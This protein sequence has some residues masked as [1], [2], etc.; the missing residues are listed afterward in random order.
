MY[1]EF[2][3]AMPHFS[4]SG[5]ILGK[6]TLFNQSEELM[7]LRRPKLKQTKKKREKRINH[8]TSETVALMCLFAMQNS[9]FKRR[10]LSSSDRCP[11]CRTGCWTCWWTDSCY[12]R[13]WWWCL[14]RPWGPHH[15]IAAGGGKKG[16]VRRSW[17]GHSK[18]RTS[19]SI[20]WSNPCPPK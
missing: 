2:I 7:D 11:V 20:L 18:Q 9:G 1:S 8:I 3:S 5:V 14:S 17:V 16:S 13:S 4:L 15:Y 12:C 6:L 10:V 19:K